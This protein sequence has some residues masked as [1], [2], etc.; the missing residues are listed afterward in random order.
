[1]KQKLL[2]TY[3]KYIAF[4]AKKHLKNKDIKIIWITWSVWKTSCRLVISK[5][6][7]DSLKNKTIYSSPENFNSD[8]WLVLSIFKVEKYSPSIFSLVKLG[9][10]LTFRSFSKPS[11]DILV[12][13]YWIDNPWD[14]DKLVNIIKPNISIFTKLDKVHSSQFSGWEDIWIE[15]FKLMHNTKDLVYLNNDDTFCL[16]YWNKLTQEV[17]FYSKSDKSEVWIKSFNYINKNGKSISSI[18]TMKW[19]IETN[20]LWKENHVYISI[21]EDISLSLWWERLSSIELD[22]KWWRFSLFSWVNDSVLIDS[23][24]NAAPESMKKMIEN[25][26]NLKNEVYKDREVILVLWDMRELWEYSAD[27]H[28]SLAPLIIWSSDHIITIWNEILVLYDELKK[29]WFNWIFRN[30]KKSSSAWEYLLDY[31]NKNK[32]KKYLILFKWSQNTIFTE[33]A[34]KRL[35]L[36]DF[37]TEK[38]VR[39]SN[40]WMKKKNEFFKI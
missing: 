30:Y 10:F 13:E 7:S 22:L 3:Y 34:L 2:N 16:N 8:L 4:L 31:I 1:M 33:E 20:L 23:T 17:K 11:Y 29:S 37:D 12:L 26:I 18:T 24:Y 19:D 15:K 28:K 36:N 35:L 27:E 5:Y 25:T 32:D 6:L 40:Y 38:L 9:L 14:M 39:Q 21:A